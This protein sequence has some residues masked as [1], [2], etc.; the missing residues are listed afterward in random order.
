VLGFFRDF[1]RDRRGAA[2]VEAAVCFPLLIL[3]GFGAFE[4]S[5]YVYQNHLML[6]G[7][8]D[9]ARY[10]ARTDCGATAVTNAKNIAVFGTYDGTGTARVSGWTTANVNVG[11]PPSGPWNVCPD[12]VPQVTTLRNGNPKLAVVTS[13]MSFTGLGVAT[14]LGLPIP[15]TLSAQH[16]ERVL[17]Q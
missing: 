11:T 16:T 7:V 15:A 2:L 5:L 4:Y 13:S 14:N 9:A 10:L 3:I 17:N 8:R 1:A 6:Q 12:A